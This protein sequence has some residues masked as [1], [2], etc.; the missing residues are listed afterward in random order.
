MHERG[1]S[2]ATSGLHGSRDAERPAFVSYRT[3]LAARPQ[4]CNARDP[5]LIG[6]LRHRDWLAGRERLADRALQG[7]RHD[8]D[9][10]VAESEQGSRPIR[11]RVR[12]QRVG[13][14]GLR[15]RR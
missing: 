7:S 1:F 12:E 13:V 15:L 10:P 4:T 9:M 5:R 11:S 14:A 3:F 2:A 8:A 6:R